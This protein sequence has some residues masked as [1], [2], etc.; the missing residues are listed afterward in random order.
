LERRSTMSKM[1][2]TL[3]AAALAVT[4]S[5]A[6]FARG[7]E[8]RV[9]VL[10]ASPDAPAV[11]VLVNGGLA[12]EDVAFTEFAGYASV[13]AGTYNVQVVPTGATSPV[14][15]DADLS[16]FYNTDYTVVAVNFLDQIEP[17]VLVDDNTPIAPVKSKV[18]F[19]HA[20]P[21]APAVDIRVANGG[22]YLFTNV[23]F[24]GVGEY[25]TV[26]AGTY[27]L[28]VTVAGTDTVALSLPNVMFDG[29]TT[30]TVF[31]VGSLAEGTLGVAVGVDNVSPARAVG[32][33]RR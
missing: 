8:S 3:F 23:S 25:V 10:H 30:Y 14:V 12:F 31:A 21:D 17:L 5:T 4:L 19:V 33:R 24:K 13:P 22:P 7:N 6:A 20:S 16:L 9:R 1:M 26:P 28:E 2:K 27:S 18:R 32:V 11:D 15:I 29:G